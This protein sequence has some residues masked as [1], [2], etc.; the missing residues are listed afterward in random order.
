M[1]K[2]LDFT[3]IVSRTTVSATGRGK[4][5][6][7]TLDGC[8]FSK[9]TFNVDRFGVFSPTPVVIKNLNAPAGEPDNLTI[10]P[11]LIFSP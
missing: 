3:L 11:V 8:N 4:R 2:K 1:R 7:Y 5:V 6:I 9:A 10:T